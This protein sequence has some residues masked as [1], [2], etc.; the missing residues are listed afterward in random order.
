M[1]R[2][3]PFLVAALLAAGSAPLSSGCQAARDLRP[4]TVVRNPTTPSTPAP[5]PAGKG[6]PA[7]AAPTAETER[8]K[9]YRE[10]ILNAVVNNPQIATLIPRKSPMGGT[11]IVGSRDD[12]QFLG[13][14]LVA[15][16]YED[17]HVAGRLLVKVDD[18]HDL[19]TWKV[20]EDKPE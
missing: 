11:W 17:G 16:D 1:K 14:G 5:S 8:K 15:I 7:D 20:L 12:V 2:F 10:T 4:G 13:S 3:H 18:P 9:R 19:K 6:S